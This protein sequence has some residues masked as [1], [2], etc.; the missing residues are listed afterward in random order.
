MELLQCG[1]PQ[2][3]ARRVARD[4]RYD[5]HQLVELV[6]RGCSPALAVQILSPVDALTR[7]PAGRGG[8]EGE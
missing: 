8:R 2:A 5:L 3:L 7:V 1:F 6:E 4:E